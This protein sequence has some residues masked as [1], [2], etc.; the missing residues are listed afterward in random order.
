MPYALLAI[1]LILGLYG[2]YRFFISATPHQVKTMIL[3]VGTGA[4]ALAM[5]V[6][7]VTGRLPAAIAV[8]AALWPVA[9]AV[10]RARKPDRA[11]GA[12]PSSQKPMSRAAALEILGLD[13]TADE[14]AIQDAYKRLMLKVHP[15]QQGSE[16]MA[17]KLNEA[18]DYLLRK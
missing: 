1:G 8:L 3:T 11:P 13:D 7:A 15:D 2:L 4:I 6:L 12:A 18:W 17:A 10:M 5:F 16:W 14:A 9:V